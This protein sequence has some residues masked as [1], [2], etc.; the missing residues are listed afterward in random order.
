MTFLLDHF[1]SAFLGSR[2]T[3]HF[4]I[5][6]KIWRQFPTWWFL[7][8]FYWLD[9]RNLNSLSL[10]YS[11]FLSQFDVTTIQISLLKG[12]FPELSRTWQ[13]K[14][15]L[16]NELFFF[17]FWVFLFF[18]S[19]LKDWVVAGTLATNDTINLLGHQEKL[20]DGG[21]ASIVT[22]PLSRLTLFKLSLSNTRLS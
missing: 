10:K 13:N 17:R 19:R 11:F 16:N 9:H 20:H 7:C 3:I 21:L 12:K 15:A 14:A 4:F 5:P 2:P 1:H 18:R 6:R 22:P 8:R